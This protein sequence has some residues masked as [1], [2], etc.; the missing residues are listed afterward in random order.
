[1]GTAAQEVVREVGVSHCNNI[2]SLTEHAHASDTTHYTVDTLRKE[3]LSFMWDLGYYLTKKERMSVVEVF[4]DVQHACDD[5]HFKETINNYHKHHF[6]I[7]RQTELKG[8]RSWALD[9]V[10]ITQMYKQLVMESKRKVPSEQTEEYINQ[11]VHNFV[12]EITQH[13]EKMRAL[14]MKARCRNAGYN[15][16]CTPLLPN[17]VE[18]YEA[19]KG[20]K[21]RRGDATWLMTH[22]DRPHHTLGLP[23]ANEPLPTGDTKSFQGGRN[24]YEQCIN[25]RKTDL[26]QPKYTYKIQR[27]QDETEARLRK[28]VEMR[29]ATTQRR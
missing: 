1:M 13:A 20:I 21:E 16:L 3:L 12:S 27:L 9:G 11:L 28:T 23:K 19:K 8:L 15:P 5:M 7:N 22:G 29:Q 18:D 2:K 10:A 4:D 26:F 14:F 17:E 25:E 24:L 6:D